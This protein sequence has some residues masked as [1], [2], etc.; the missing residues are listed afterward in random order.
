MSPPAKPEAAAPSSGMMLI[1][2][3]G[4]TVRSGPSKSN[5]ALFAL[6][7]GQKVTV[8]SNQKGWLQIVDA[9]GRTGW[10]YSALLIKQ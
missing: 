3:Q 5:G 4:V 2:G 7:A 8:K 1:G 10:A 9:Q 6:A